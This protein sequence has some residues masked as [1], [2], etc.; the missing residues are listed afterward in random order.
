MY[1]KQYKTSTIMDSPKNKG[2]NILCICAFHDASVTTNRI[3]RYLPSSRQG[4]EINIR[5]TKKK[6][7]NST[8]SG[9]LVLSIVS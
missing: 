7:K 4:I 3:N 9:V 8:P 2:V 6:K 1:T 5:N